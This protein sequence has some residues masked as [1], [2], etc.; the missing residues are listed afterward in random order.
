VGF[1][2]AIAGLAVIVA[3]F[4]VKLA[5]D[6]IERIGVE[7]LLVIGVKGLLAFE[8]SIFQALVD[9]F[10]VVAGA[11]TQRLALGVVAYRPNQHPLLAVA[12]DA[13]ELT[14]GK[15]I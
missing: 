8:N 1:W 13:A 11:G 14:R 4:A 2:A 7:R 6:F 3:D 15:G 10:E 12:A 9:V 5:Y